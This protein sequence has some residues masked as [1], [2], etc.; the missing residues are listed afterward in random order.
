MPTIFRLHPRPFF[1][2]HALTSYRTGK[3]ER[4]SRYHRKKENKEKGSARG[5]EFKLTRSKKEKKSFSTV[6]TIL[7]SDRARTKLLFFFPLFSAHPLVSR[8]PPRGPC[9]FS[10]LF[11][12]PPTQRESGEGK[13]K[14]ERTKYPVSS[15]VHFGPKFI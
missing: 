14:R 15:L 6:C 2:P 10:L 3:K 9:R 5:Q 1:S 4:K 7:F 11:P 8:P 13:E 12:P